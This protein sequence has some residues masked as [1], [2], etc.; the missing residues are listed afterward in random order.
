MNREQVVDK[1]L[2]L[3]KAVWRRNKSGYV[4]LPFIPHE[5]ARGPERKTSLRNGPAFK[6]GEWDR[7]REHLDDHHRD[8]LYFAPMVF[9][10][11]RRRREYASL[12]ARLWADLDA[13]DPK[14]IP[15][16]LTPNILWETSPGR[17][18]GVWFMVSG[19]TETTERGGENHRL[20]IALGAD[21]SGWDTTQLLRV[22]LSA[23]NKPG[24]PEGIRGKLVSAES[25][26]HSW[27]DIDTL[28]ELAEVDVRG[29]DVFEEE[30][31]ESV[32]PF[33]AFARM[34]RSLPSRVRQYMRLKVADG[35][36]DR[37]NI[38]WEIERSLADAGATLLEMVAIMRPTP[39]NKFEG[40]DDEL[41]R[42]TLEC[43][44]ALAM[45]KEVPQA[46]DKSRLDQDEDITHKLVP[47]W[48]N[49][50]YLTAPEPEWLY[51]EF[52][53]EGGCG[54]IAGIP[55]SMKS[56]LALDLAIS[57]AQG[58]SY[59]G[60]KSAGP[61]NVLYFQ[62]EDPTTLVRSRHHVIASSKDASWS[63]DRPIRDLRPYPGTLYVETNVGIEINDESWQVWLSE[64]IRQHDIKLVIF[65]TLV[66]AAPGVEF[67]SATAITAEVLNP[68]KEISRD[69]NCSMIFVH[70][71]TKSQG[72]ERAGQNMA[73]SGQIHAWADFGIYVK[74]KKEFPNHVDLTFDH[75]TKYTGT[76]T[77]TF[78]VTGLPERWDIEEFVKSEPVKKNG[79]GSLEIDMSRVR[80][81][82]TRTWRGLTKGAKNSQLVS[83]YIRENPDAK[84][85]EIADATELSLSVVRHHLKT[86]KD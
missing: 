38:A 28:P 43:G 42:L 57:A 3:L 37:S 41:K 18:A 16:D 19:R 64:M 49:E 70:H 78:R 22:P 31:L 71:N 60:Y 67:D 44:K 24:Y 26:G 15:A 35:T 50:A 68:V 83:A 1:Q 47:F 74:D 80:P 40:R 85:Q 58:T 53:P 5:H 75:E 14:A 17:Y 27:E 65:D 48:R 76:N 77:M 34:R 62:R 36:M 81:P 11:P 52:I 59:L 7:I 33:E 4:F 86:K 54:F 30:L 12:C 55:K 21:P 66:R 73:G 69:M 46:E 2:S 6:I 45:K 63:L 25:G 72:N 9:T 23:N 10:Q 20:T 29:G 39:W 13:I 82:R 61:I 8:E 32:N 84:A 79:D 51:D 56:W